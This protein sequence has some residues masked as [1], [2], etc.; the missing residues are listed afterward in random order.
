MMTSGCPEK[1]EKR[2]PHKAVATSISLTPINLSVFSPG[3]WVGRC[4]CVCVCVFVCV[5]VCLCVCVCVCVCVRVC[6]CVCLPKR[7]PK[8]MA[9]ERQAK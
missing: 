4:V 2:V 7:P 1:R 8:V 3:G 9:G 5:C 6:V